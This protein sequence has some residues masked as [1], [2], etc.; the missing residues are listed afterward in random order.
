MGPD[1]TEVETFV[2]ICVK[3]RFPGLGFCFNMIL[4]I[5]R[6]VQQTPTNYSEIFQY[7]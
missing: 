6:V 3:L 2:R 4:L 1:R 7:H 5:F